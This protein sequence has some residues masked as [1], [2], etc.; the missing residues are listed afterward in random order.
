MQAW[1]DSTSN[2]K[3]TNHSQRLGR[4]GEDVRVANRRTDNYY[5]EYASDNEKAAKAEAISH[6]V[7]SSAAD[8]H[9]RKHE[10]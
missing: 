9:M 8:S 7:S 4:A 5:H 3:C 1:R 2:W 6:A 10:Q